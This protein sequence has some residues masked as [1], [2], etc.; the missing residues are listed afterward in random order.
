MSLH[1]YH[2]LGPTGIPHHHRTIQLVKALVDDLESYAYR[3]DTD[4]LEVQVERGG[5]ATELGQREDGLYGVEVEF[6]RPLKCGEIVTLLYNTTFH[7]KIAPDPVLRRQARRLVENMELNVQFDP[8]KLPARLW[9]AS[10]ED[11]DGPD[12]DREDIALDEDLS[13]SRYLTTVKDTIVG[14]VWQW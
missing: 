14:F 1:E 3:F 7:Y 12:I 8:L 2:Y 11:R 10:W 13:A 4:E 5:R 6:Y 9:W